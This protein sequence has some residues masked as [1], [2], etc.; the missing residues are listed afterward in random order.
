MFTFQ[1][2][3]TNI[4]R[5]QGRSDWPYPQAV[6]SESIATLKCMTSNRH[7]LGL[8]SQIFQSAASENHPP[9]P[10]MNLG[11]SPFHQPIIEHILYRKNAEGCSAVT[12]VACGITSSAGLASKDGRLRKETRPHSREGDRKKDATKKGGEIE[13]RQG[14]SKSRIP[15]SHPSLN[16]ENRL[17]LLG[18]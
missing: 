15:N 8:K 10:A 3:P 13:R 1:P 16:A 4:R 17:L 12:A 11:P 18:W 7:E 5:L 14:I 6:K 9:S 2:T